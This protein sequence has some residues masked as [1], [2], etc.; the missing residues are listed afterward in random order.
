MKEKFPCCR[1]EDA[2]HISANHERLSS[3]LVA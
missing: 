3:F 1:A 2:G